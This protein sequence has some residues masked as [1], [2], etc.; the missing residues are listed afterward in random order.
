MGTGKKRPWHLRLDKL[1]HLRSLQQ[2]LLSLQ[3]IGDTFL[4]E[5]VAADHRLRN[6]ALRLFFRLHGITTDWQVVEATADERL[7]NTLAMICPFQPSEKQALLEAEALDERA[8]IMT[9]L[10]EMAVTNRASGGD[11]RP[12]SRH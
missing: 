11:G 7:V 9:A 1:Q 5:R 12:A 10:M 6:R 2:R 4:R 3:H 8:A